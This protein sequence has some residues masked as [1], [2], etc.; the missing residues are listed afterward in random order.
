MPMRI[1][2]CT[3]LKECI[4]TTARLLCT[5]LT[6]HGELQEAMIS[7]ADQ[8]TVLDDKYRTLSM[9]KR[10][11]KVRSLMDHGTEDLTK[12]L[13]PQSLGP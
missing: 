7:L 11:F 1:L 10:Q 4:L 8:V 6:N 12:N 5:Q 3:Q 9:Q 2:I 13:G